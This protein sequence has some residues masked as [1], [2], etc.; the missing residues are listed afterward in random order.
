[1]PG[2]TAGSSGSKFLEGPSLV[3]IPGNLGQPGLLG[4]AQGFSHETRS[5]FGGLRP[6][7]EV[8]D[9]QSPEKDIRQV[10][11]IL[12]MRCVKHLGG[13]F[14]PAGDKRLP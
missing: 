12:A 8:P 7:R 13:Y 9:F 5:R 6:Y 1:M 4:P 2:S 3:E 10:V 11:G 14:R